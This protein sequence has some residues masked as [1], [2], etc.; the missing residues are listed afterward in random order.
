MS[1]EVSYAAVGSFGRRRQ[2][3]CFPEE[4]GASFVGGGGFGRQRRYRLQSSEEVAALVVV[5]GSGFGRHIRQA[6]LKW[7]EREPNLILFLKIGVPHI[8]GKPC[9]TRIQ[10]CW[11]YWWLEYLLYCIPSLK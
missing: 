4:A 2:R 1:E 11:A 9:S 6:R 10:W 8:D 7:A 5:G 3:L